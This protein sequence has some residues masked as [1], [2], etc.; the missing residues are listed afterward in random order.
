MNPDKSCVDYY[1][2]IK[3]EDKNR[4]TLLSRVMEKK[5]VTTDQQRIEIMANLEL[6]QEMKIIKGKNLDGIGLFRT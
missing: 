5:C 4:K 1:N 2:Q 3:K 6:P